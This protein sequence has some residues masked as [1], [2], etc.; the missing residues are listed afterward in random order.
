L[1]E[2]AL[3][4][5]ISLGN[6]AILPILSFLMHEHGV[7]VYQDHLLHISEMFCGFQSIHSS[8]FLLNI[9][10]NGIFLTFSLLLLHKKY[11]LFFCIDSVSW[12][13]AELISSCS[14]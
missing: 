8:I 1:T 12:S 5:Y 3:N 9:L 6:T 4:L 10:A 2:I 14:F 7:P 11:N 13:L